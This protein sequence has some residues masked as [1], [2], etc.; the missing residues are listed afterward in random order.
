MIALKAFAL[1]K[2]KA[3]MTLKKQPNNEK[4]SHGECKTQ[5][6]LGGLGNISQQN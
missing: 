4:G 5:A 2:G 1:M 6:H 3:F